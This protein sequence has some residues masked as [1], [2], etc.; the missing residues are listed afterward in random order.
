M[1]WI[2]VMKYPLFLNKT[3]LIL[4]LLNELK[5]RFNYIYKMDADLT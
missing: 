1:K 5:G 2:I 3:G 4:F